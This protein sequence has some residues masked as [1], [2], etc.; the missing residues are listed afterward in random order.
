MLHMELH[1]LQ[2]LQLTMKELQTQLTGSTRE[3]KGITKGSTKWKYVNGII[4][5]TADKTMKLWTLSLML[6]MELYRQLPV[7][8]LQTG[9][10]R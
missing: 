4:I 2:H 9:S 10:T 7:K 1:L 5:Y 6:H 8:D 3:S